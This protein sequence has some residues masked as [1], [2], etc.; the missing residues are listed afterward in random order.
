MKTTIRGGRGLDLRERCTWARCRAQPV[1][2]MAALMMFLGAATA[3]ADQP[4]GT[5]K[6]QAT[7]AFLK[8][9]QAISR[10]LAEGGFLPVESFTNAQ[11]L[12]QG[13]SRYPSAKVLAECC[14]Y[15]FADG[16]LYRIWRRDLFEN[17]GPA[18][19]ILRHLTNDVLTLSREAAPAQALEVLRRLSCD[20]DWL[21]DHSSIQA[22]E[23]R[24]IAQPA[25]DGGPGLPNDNPFHGELI[26]R[27]QIQLTVVI[28]ARHLEAGKG[29]AGLPAETRIGLLA[30]DGHLLS[31][32]CLPSLPK[33]SWSGMKPAERIVIE[34]AVDFTPPLFVSVTRHLND[35]EAAQPQPAAA[36][37]LAAAWEDL[38][39]RLGTNVPKCILLCDNLNDPAA[40]AAAMR[41]LAGETPWAGVSQFFRFDLPFET[42]SIER[43]AS[44]QR[45][46]ALLAI[47]GAMDTKLVLVPD[48]EGIQL[49][50]EPAPKEAERKPRQG[51]SSDV[52]R[53]RLAHLATR[54]IE[55]FQIPETPP[56]HALFL[57]RAAA[58]TPPIYVL[59]DCL[60]SALPSPRGVTLLMGTKRQGVSYSPESGATYCNGQVTT[61]GFVLLRVSGFLPLRYPRERELHLAVLRKLNDAKARSY[62]AEPLPRFL[63]E[64][65]I[66]PLE[67]LFYSFGVN[68]FEH[69]VARF[70]TD[71]I[72]MLQTADR[73]EVFQIDP[74]QSVGPRRPSTVLMSG[75]RVLARGKPLD[76]QAIRAFA[77]LILSPENDVIPAELWG[78]MEPWQPCLALRAWQGQAF[79]DFL[80]DFGIHGTTY[81]FHSPSNELICSG[82]G[83]HIA[84]RQ[85]FLKLV[86][87]ALPG[88]EVPKTKGE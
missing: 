87:A 46:I 30:T 20:A 69:V 10:A 82:G 23:T 60:R 57:L 36:P 58:S 19:P 83:L 56:D 34:G 84:N 71:Q 51:R 29:T 64:E 3:V 12:L 11:V 54:L 24:M 43:L 4:L 81:S 65:A 8:R 52:P 85:G 75:R 66:S 35:A 45:G 86:R 47:C 73:L 15:E 80:V 37:F 27:K 32:W 70:G 74:W 5:Y 55:R 72:R 22:T 88:F 6:E 41:S 17:K 67:V 16:F 79:A 50:G 18:S 42:A 9:A 26:A 40:L 13:Q 31:A 25:R 77:E 14:G 7:D 63:A 2:C 68:P 39:Q 48:E 61:N 38:Q 1:W 76:R 21:R 28:G 62:E 53:D 49:L 78:S 33:G 59:E 44:G